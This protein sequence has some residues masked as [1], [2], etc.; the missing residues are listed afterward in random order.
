MT[1]EDAES[2]FSRQGG[3]HIV[4]LDEARAIENANAI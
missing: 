4:T 1:R 3:R 2:V